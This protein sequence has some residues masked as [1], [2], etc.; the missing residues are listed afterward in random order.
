MFIDLLLKKNGKILFFVFLVIFMVTTSI[1]IVFVV[2]NLNTNV[3]KFD[4]DGYALYLDE[5]KSA[6]AE[7]NNIP[8]FIVIVILKFDNDKFIE[9]EWYSAYCFLK[10]ELKLIKRLFKDIK[11]LNSLTEI[12]LK[13]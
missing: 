6:K 2:N 3:L 4:K 10:I 5:V 11:F 7:N 12:S 8:F 13:K 9:L 1:G